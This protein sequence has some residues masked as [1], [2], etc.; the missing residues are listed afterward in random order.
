MP[1][2]A[3]VRPP[4]RPDTPPGPGGRRPQGSAAYGGV[5]GVVP[6]GGSSANYATIIVKP[7][8]RG[9]PGVQPERVTLIAKPPHALDDAPEVFRI[10]S[11]AVP[12][13]DSM[14]SVTL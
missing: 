1:H 10:G 7:G 14:I 6:V 9:R 5:G 2:A 11:A 12:A 3:P 13:D 4:T 8:R